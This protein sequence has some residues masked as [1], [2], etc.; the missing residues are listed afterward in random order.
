MF[1]D[2]MVTMRWSEDAGWHEGRLHARQPLTMDPAAA[3]L[4]YAQ[5]IF[6]GL[7]AYRTDDGGVAL[8]RPEANARRFQESARRLAM[9]P[10]P[11]EYFVESVRALVAQEREW[12]PE[13][14]GGALYLRPFMIASE[15]FLGVKPAGE[16]LYMVLA[17]ATGA[18]WKGGARA[19]SLWVSHEHSRAAAG[20]TGAAKCGGNYASSLVAQAEAIRRGCD[21]VV[22][23]D[24]AERRWIEELGGMNIF[25]LFADGSMV[26]PPLTG[27]IL[28]GITR[29]S[30]LRMARDEGVDAREEQYSIDQWQE[31]AASGRLVEAFACGTAAVVTPIGRVAGPDYGFTIGDGGTGPRTA[32]ILERLS[33][34]QRGRAPDPHGWLQRVD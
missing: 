4:H 33:D 9:P 12:I 30:I 32:R 17:S 28:P 20:G 25:F 6:E 3:V 10:L 27:T 29:D 7:K 2:H 8:F 22:F 26:T 11:E 21:Q 19:I 15:V 5:E 34:L 24:A 14:E 16:Y 1:T 31:D 18:Y 23:L 13:I